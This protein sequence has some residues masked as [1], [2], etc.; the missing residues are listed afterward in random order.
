MNSVFN[1]KPICHLQSAVL[2]AAEALRPGRP[3]PERVQ[4][5]LSV[6]KLGACRRRCLHREIFSE[7]SARSVRIQNSSQRAKTLSKLHRRLE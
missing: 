1:E 3:G 6:S 5:A 7:K 2:P 4:H